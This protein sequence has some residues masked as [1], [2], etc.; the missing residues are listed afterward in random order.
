MTA[1]VVRS[2]GEADAGEQPEP[3][4]GVERLAQ[5]DGDD[6]G[7]RDASGWGWRQWCPVVR[8]VA[9]VATAAVLVV[10]RLL[11]AWCR[12]V[13]SWW[14][15]SRWVS[16]VS[17][18]N[19]SSSPAPSAVRSSMSGMPASWA[20]DRPTR[21]ASASASRSASVGRVG[22]TATPARSVRRFT[23]RS[24]CRVR[25]WVPAEASSSVLVPCGDDA[26]VADD[27][28]VVGDDLDLV[29]QVRGQQDGGAA[30]GV[31]A[32]QVAHPADAGRVQ[33]VGGFVEDQDLGVAEQRVRDAQ[34]LPHAEGVVAHAAVGL[35]RR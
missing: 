26:P 31:A 25:T 28:E 27:D 34:P 21:S 30:V 10:M 7:E 6:A 13:G 22:C 33:T 35:R 18:R 15:S 5:L 11:L 2:D 8:S 23:S 20:S 24:G 17:S 1:P 19:I 16:A 9:W 14:G 3:G 4:P 32:E 12:R 29:Q